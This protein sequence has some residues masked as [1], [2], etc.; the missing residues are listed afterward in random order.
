M[1]NSRTS[2]STTKFTKSPRKGN[3]SKLN[4]RL[5]NFT[6]KPMV[7]SHSVDYVTGEI[8]ATIHK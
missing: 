5:L 7:V 8:K 3:E 2:T 4:R 1:K 6:P